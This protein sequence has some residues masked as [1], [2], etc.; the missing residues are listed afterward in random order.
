MKTGTS[1]SQSDIPVSQRVYDQ[2][3]ESIISLNW[4]PGQRVSEKDVSAMLGVSKTPVREAFIRLSEEGLMEIRPQ[5]GSYVSRISF[6]RVYESLMLRRA[7]E[8]SVAAEAAE[9]RSVLDL[10]NLQELIECQVEA[11]GRG[12]AAAFFD[13]DREFHRLLAEIA[14]M[15]SA[16]RMIR[17]LRG[18]VDRVQRLRIS[19]GESRHAQVVEAHRAIVAAIKERDRTAASAAMDAHLN[20]VELFAQIIKSPEVREHV[21]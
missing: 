21:A 15:P 17:M 7:L 1:N 10:V 5:S 9:Q 2:I 4:D 8:M 19:R 14:K 6:E 16:I 3:R 11:A 20:C 12:D 13:L 18:T